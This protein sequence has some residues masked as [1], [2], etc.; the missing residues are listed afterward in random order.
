M[1]P[2]DPE[3]REAPEPGRVASTPDWPTL[4]TTLI[5]GSDLDANTTRWALSEVM[6]GRADDAKLAGLLI[7]LRAKGE[8]VDEITGLAQGMLDHASP[9]PVPGISLDIVGTGG[10]GAG[11]LNVSTAAAVVAA[12]AGV[13]VVKHGNRA[14]S[15]QCGS[16]DVL[17]ALGVSIDLDPPRVA[18]IATEVGITFA[19]AQR[20]H[21]AMRHAAGVRRSLGVRTAF[22]VLG[23][24]TNPARPAAM[25]VG[26]SEVRW[27]P[28]LAGVL[29]RNRVSALVFRSDDGVDELTSVTGADVWVVRSGEVART[30]F[31]PRRLDLAVASA[32]D[33]AGGDARFNATRVR[34]I[35]AGEHGPA[36]DTIALNAAAGLLATDLVDGPA[37]GVG[38]D[39][40]AADLTTYLAEPLR[41]ARAV[42]ANGGAGQLLDRWAAATTR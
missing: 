38:A 41:R 27:A 22:N 21:P 26:V 29:A 37:S 2:V 20:F 4:L 36:A 28:V 34:Q 24:L 16:A 9:L 3:S 13:V 10:D 6:T 39:A 15:S 19:F 11:T 42:L 12:S 5:A 18:D 14:A 30:R 1:I 33:L 25:A 31:D 7:G 17:E 8:T 23:P 35:L 32:A 40:V